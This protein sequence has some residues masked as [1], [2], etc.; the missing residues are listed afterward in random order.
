MFLEEK[1]L[2][3]EVQAPKP[4][5]FD[6]FINWL[7]GQDPKTTYCYAFARDCLH[8]RYKRSLGLEYRTPF[9][10]G[11]F[12]DRTKWDD[13]QKVEY[14]AS[15]GATY[16]EALKAAYSLRKSLAAGR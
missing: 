8:C 15:Q 12:A 3:V 13:E 7:E 10:G 11:P 1:N 9:L 16:G 4:L 14:C 2:N 5:T 6:H